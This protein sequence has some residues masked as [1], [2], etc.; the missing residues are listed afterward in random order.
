MVVSFDPL[1]Q[2]CSVPDR[3][4]L[5]HN[6]LAWHCHTASPSAGGLPLVASWPYRLPVRLC[7]G[8]GEESQ[9]RIRANRYIGGD[10]AFLIDQVAD[11]CPENRVVA[12]DLP[13][14]L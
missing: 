6:I 1:R 9:D 12:R 8:T 14:S 2:H 7:H 13:L 3:S 10:H 11:R 4:A 5:W